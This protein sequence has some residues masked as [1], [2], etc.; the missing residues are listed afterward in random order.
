MRPNIPEPLPQEFADPL[1][2]AADRL[3]PFSGRVRWYP[4][5]SSTNDVAAALADSGVDE[6]TVVAADAQTAGRVR[7]GRPWASPAGVGIYATTVLRPHV[8][9]AALITIAAGVAVAEGIEAATGLP[10]HVKW[11]N[12]VFVPGHGGPS[13]GRKVAGILAEGGAASDGRAWVVLGFGINV[14]PGAYPPDVAA[15]ATSL[16][17]EL[18]RA[19]D[20]GR[21]LTECLVAL[22][23]RYEDLG[24]QRGAAVVT[25]W[26][27]RAAGTFG[28]RVEWDHRGQV[29]QGV[30]Q[31]VDRT[32][33]LLV[34]T[35][36]GV[37]R[38]ISGEVRWI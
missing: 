37:E 25:S 8:D 23:R 1:T 26:R 18:G 9:A 10:V 22:A 6:G 14:L 35:S 29:Q 3:G 2:R 5:V 13:T 30:A 31:D 4:V 21:V 20:R 28:R 27:A 38:V 19:V 34:S 32:G 7:Q 12:D 11:P 17:T 36:T 15:R 24:A 16:E 33:A